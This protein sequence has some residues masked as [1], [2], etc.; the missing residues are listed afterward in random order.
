MISF[1]RFFV[2]TTVAGTV[3]SVFL[4]KQTKFYGENHGYVFNNLTRIFSISA[5]IDFR[6]KLVTL[7]VRP[8]YCRHLLASATK[9][10]KKLLASFSNQ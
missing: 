9:V 5:N 4:E 2:N 1:S 7:S 8:I 6:I 10:E 3:F